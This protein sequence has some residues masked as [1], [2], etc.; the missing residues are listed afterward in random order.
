MDHLLAVAEGTGADRVGVVWVDEYGPGLAHPHRVLD[1]LA[2]QPRRRYVASLLAA[3]RERGV[4][5]VLELRGSDLRAQDGAGAWSFSVALGSDGTRAWFLVADSVTPGPSLGEAAREDVLFRAGECASLL[6]HRDLPLDGGS[7]GGS[8]E[9]AVH[10]FPGWGI[11]RDVEGIDEDDPVHRRVSLRFSAARLVLGYLEE[12][13]VLPEERR[14][15][16]AARLQEEFTARQAEDFEDEVPLWSRLLQR[17]Q[18]GDAGDL[19]GLLVEWGRLVESQGHVYGAGEI[20]QAAFSLAV[21]CGD[22]ETAVDAA[23]QAGR[24]ARHRGDW[25][26]SGSWY[27]VARDVSEAAGWPARTAVVLEGSAIA[28]RERGNLPAARSVLK[29]A[30]EVADDASDAFAR[31]RV[32][33]GFLNLEH[34]AHNLPDAARHGWKAVELYEG[35]EDRVRCLAGLGG[36]LLEMGELDASQD[37]WRLVDHLAAQKYY[38]LYAA[39]ALSHIAAL[40]GDA[41][42]FGRLA[43]VSDR[44][45]WSDG[46]SAAKGQI[47]LHRGLSY[48]ALDRRDEAR[49]WLERAVSYAGN[50]E[51]HQILFEAEEAL[52]KLDAVASAREEPAPDDRAT[53][54]VATEVGAGLQTMREALVGA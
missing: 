44:L 34:A 20:L 14:R 17:F 49:S 7:D 36:L 46:P 30:M 19:S 43:A 32:H 2:D 54:P 16:Q 18:A 53:T 48:Q 27:D 21:A 25:E 47:L 11:L 6:L 51:L 24:T 38:R 4:P 33:H 29:R 26:E 15:D 22:A 10:R 35:A 40:R 5:G 1:L 3:V 12:D 13:L 23:Q 37:A 8:S 39:D 28:Y 41:A 45:G 31:A 50:A 52:A 42:E 9:A